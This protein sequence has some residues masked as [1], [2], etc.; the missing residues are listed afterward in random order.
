VA[1][2]ES[3]RIGI[4]VHL[5]QMQNQGITTSMAFKQYSFLNSDPLYRA[6]LAYFCLVFKNASL[7]QNL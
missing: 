4:I 5:A 7:F 2:E 6:A 3:N 1:K